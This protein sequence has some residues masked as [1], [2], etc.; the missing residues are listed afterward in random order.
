MTGAGS[1]VVWPVCPRAGSRTQARDDEGAVVC[2][3]PV[4]ILA[5]N[6]LVVEPT[7]HLLG[8]IAPEGEDLRDSCYQFLLIFSLPGALDSS[9]SVGMEGTRNG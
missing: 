1:V 7:T 4:S 9:M 8:F 3:P 6:V 5:E 2:E